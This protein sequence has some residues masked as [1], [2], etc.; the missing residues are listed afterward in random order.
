MKSKK[1]KNSKPRPKLC[2]P[3]L[4][5]CCQ[6]IGEGDFIC[7]KHQEVVV[8]D[9]EPTENFLMCKGGNSNA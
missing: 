6:Y 1:K 3:A 2:D 4:C 8:A 7:D 5:D 9:W